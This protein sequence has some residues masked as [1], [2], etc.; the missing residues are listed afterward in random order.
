MYLKMSEDLQSIPNSAA[1]SKT[2]PVN[3]AKLLQ[4]GIFL[5][6]LPL[7]GLFIAAKATIHWLGWEIWDFDSLTASLLSAATFA[8]AILLSN[9]LADYRNSE[10]LPMQ[11]VN[12]LETITDTNRTIAAADL[13][14]NPKPLQ[15]A[16]QQVSQSIL[17]W[18][19]QDGDFQAISQ[20]LDQLNPL[21]ALMISGAGITPVNRL[22]GEQA[23]IRSISYQMKN[24]RDTDFL[25]PIYV[26]LWLFLSGSSISLLLVHANYFSK[27]LTVS[28]LIFTS[29]FYLLLLIRDLDNPF[30][31]DGKSYVDV[32]LAILENCRDQLNLE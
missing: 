19:Q 9:T 1:V 15:A 20:K 25:P 21:F 4:W 10:V 11:I 16:L 18:L 32:D 22:H 28:S 27:D 17:D 5:Q 23:R 8:I 29:S 14:Y 13:N 30:Q 24:I 2:L 31:Y 7:A 12:S 26:L 6:V 3:S